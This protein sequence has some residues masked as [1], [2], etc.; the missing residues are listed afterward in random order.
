MFSEAEAS[1]RMWDE[2][3]GQLPQMLLWINVLRHASQ[4]HGEQNEAFGHWQINH[5][6][7]SE[8]E[9][10]HFDGFESDNQ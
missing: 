9:H 2:K 3:K 8:R 4:Q 6:P 10:K 1:G 5:L 7:S